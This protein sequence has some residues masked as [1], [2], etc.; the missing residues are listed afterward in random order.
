ME[1]SPFAG[2]AKQ[3]AKYRNDYPDEAIRVVIERTGLT[4]SEVVVDLGSGTALLTRRLLPCAKLVYAV[5]PAEDMR[6]E[7][8][9]SVA[10]EPKFRSVAGSAEQT[11]LPSACAD[12]IVSGNAFHY[13]DPER[14]RA[15]AIRILRPGGRVAILFNDIPAAP[16]D[17]TK[18]YLAFLA[19]ITPPALRSVHSTHDHKSRVAAFLGGRP[20]VLDTGE[21]TESLSW[22]AL[23]GLFLSSSLADKAALPELRGIYDRHQPVKLTLAWTCLSVR[24]LVD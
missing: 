20:A 16:N 13:F 5:E 17:F 24:T 21:Q 2:K 15:E 10:G 22:D 4:G 11:G 23:R 14:A 8:E 19:R 12:A 18:E 9:A 6:R 7:V 3:Y 1:R